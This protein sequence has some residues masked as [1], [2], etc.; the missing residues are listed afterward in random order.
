MTWSAT[1]RNFAR[2]RLRRRSST[3]RLDHESLALPAAGRDSPSTDARKVVK[4]FGS[5]R[6]YPAAIAERGRAGEATRGLIR[7][8]GEMRLATWRRFRQALFSALSALHTLAHRH[9]PRRRWSR[10]AARGIDA[11]C[12]DDR[13]SFAHYTGLL[14]AFIRREDVPGRLRL[15]LGRH[16]GLPRQRDI[17]FSMVTCTMASSPIALADLHWFLADQYELIGREQGE[18]P[19]DRCPR[20]RGAGY[21]C[22]YRSTAAPLN[23]PSIAISPD[24]PRWRPCQASK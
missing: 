5:M 8:S 16:P 23:D 18:R 11:G 6:G 13:L 15:D 2:A 10:V 17:G 1:P 19:H 3:H 24:T 20:C 22:E 21:Q 14:Y 12:R 7:R 9:R 4:D